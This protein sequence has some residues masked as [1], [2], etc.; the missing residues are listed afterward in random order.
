MNRLA[1]CL[2]IVACLCMPRFARGQTPTQAP[3]RDTPSQATPARDHQATTGTGVIRGRIVEATG[4]H[5]LSRVEVRAGPNAGQVTG[6]IAYTD[7]DGRYEI[8]NLPAGTYTIIAQ[9][10]NYVRTSWGE[11]RAEGPGKRIPLADGQVLEHYDVKIQR[12]GAITGRILDEFGDPVT[13]VSVTTMHYQYV[14]GSRRL[15][16][17][18]GASTND[19]GEYRIFGLVPG[20]YYVS[21][22]LREM[23]F[24]TV[25]TIASAY[26]PTYYPGTGNI[27]EAQ[28]VTIAPGQTIAGMNLS[29]QPVRTARITGVALDDDGRPLAGAFVSLISN[30]IGFGM[31]TAGVVVQHDGTFTVGGVTPGEYVLRTF[32]TGTQSAATATVSVSGSDVKDVQLIAVK[33]S[34]LR[35]RIVFTDSATSAAPPKPTAFDLGAM[36]DFSAGQAVRS[37]ATIKD[38]GTFEIALPAGHVLIRG[39]QR[40]QPQ[41]L[42]NNNGPSPWRINRVLFNDIDVGD[43]GIDVPPNGGVENVIVEMTNRTN[44]VSGRVTDADGS[45]VRDVFVIVFAQDP[46]HW[47]VQT[48]HLSVGRPGLDDRY[49]ARL[50]AGDYYAVAISDV[51]TNAWTDSDFLSAVRDRATKFSIAD[52]ETKTIDLHV[53]PPPVY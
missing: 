32:S 31:P 51:E 27:T 33:P 7:A 30:S 8:K 23:S 12:A 1:V 44:E 37:P 10:P 45:I 18:G 11:Q 17:T 24:Q 35:G 16:N 48:R 20:Q 15:V 2:L 21:A 52:G 40:Q 29:L 26:A 49:H 42:A 41:Q 19:I 14:Q 5:G 46:V 47:T 28:R 6:R 34:T 22:T 4:G 3:T 25:T 39:I 53:S 9:K 38:D 13:D 43:T 36:R 50:L